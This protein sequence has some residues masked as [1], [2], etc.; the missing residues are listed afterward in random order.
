[1][2]IKGGATP[3]AAAESLVKQPA[4]KQ[5]IR[6]ELRRFHF[7]RA[8]EPVPPMPGFLECGLDVCG[9]AKPIH[10]CARFFFVVRLP[11]KKSDL[12]GFSR[13]DLDHNLQ[14]GARIE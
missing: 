14:G 3:D 6:G 10:E 9:I 11:E 7:D 12:G 13:V 1:R 4:I 8:Q 5:K 2:L